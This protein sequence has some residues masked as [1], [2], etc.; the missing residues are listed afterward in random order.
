[1]NSNT[2]MMVIAVAAGV[3]AMALGF[4]FLQQANSGANVGTA[5][6]P[7]VQVLRAATD[8]PLGLVIETARH[9]EET[10]I[11]ESQ[12]DAR[13][14][15]PADALGDL[16]G[17][18][19]AVAKLAGQFIQYADLRSMAELDFPEGMR[20]V[21]FEITRDNAHGGLVVP[22]DRV[23][24]VL[25]YPVAAAIP[26]TSAPAPTINMNDT[27]NPEAMVSQILSQAMATG[28]GQAGGGEEWESEIVLENVRILA[29]DN[30]VAR[31]RRQI[32]GLMVL[33]EDA[34]VQ[35]DAPETMTV[36]VT[37]EQALRFVELTAPGSSIVSVI[38]R[39]PRESDAMTDVGSRLPG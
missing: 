33:P 17:T 13:I 14:T 6:E 20:A 36:E 10:S 2:V 35:V 4:V 29:V 31:N 32:A 5:V 39:S 38:L 18:T 26:E 8:I 11:P 23:D 24:I 27:S 15:M 22:G 34:A 30:D 19:L 21:T 25:S 37:P 28:M 9:I 7:Q 3:V 12:F 16:E 1:M